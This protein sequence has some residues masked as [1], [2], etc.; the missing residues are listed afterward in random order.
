MIIRKAQDFGDYTCKA[1]NKMGSATQTLALKR[2]KKPRTPT[3][4][5]LHL[6]S[7]G[8]AVRVVNPPDPGRYN[9]PATDGDKRPKAEDLPVIGYSVQYKMLRKENWITAYNVTQTNYGK[10]PHTLILIL[11]HLLCKT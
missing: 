1:I 11:L 9:D 4:H 5:V 6:G 10:F 7:T 8:V 2:A 3:L